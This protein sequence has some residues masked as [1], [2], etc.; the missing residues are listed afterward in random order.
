MDVVDNFLIKHSPTNSKTFH[1]QFLKYVFGD[2]F[3]AFVYKEAMNGPF[4]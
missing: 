3:D 1:Q 4:I 2:F